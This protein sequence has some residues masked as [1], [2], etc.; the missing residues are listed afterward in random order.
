MLATKEKEFKMLEKAAAEFAR[1]ELS[2][3]RE[4][5]DKYPFGPFWDDI[6]KKA[7]DLDFFHVLLPETLEGMGLGMQSFCILL[8]NICEVDASLAGIIFTNSMAQEIILAT[9]GEPVLKSM[10]DTATDVYGHLFAFPAFANP[11]EIEPTVTAVPADDGRYELSGPMEYLVLGNIAGNAL[12]PAKIKGKTGYV[13]FTCDMASDGVEKSE[14][15]LSLGLHACPAVD[16]RFFRAKADLIGDAG[17]GKAVFDAVSTRMQCAAAAMAAGIMKGSFK[18][19]FDY[20]K[21]R[22]QGGRQIIKWSEVQM[23][24]AEMAVQVKIAETVVEQAGR[25]IDEK[26][27]GW[28]DGSQAAAIHVCQMACDH[29]CNGIQILGGVGYMKDYGQEKRFRD[30]QQ[31]QSLLGLAPMKKIGYIHRKMQRI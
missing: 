11:S 29:T 3:N 25:S 17:N 2:P 10:M 28:E 24:L 15:V 18:E 8:E 23:I 9:G 21:E 16:V 27:K 12:I 4:E 6:V 7:F 31:I 26:Q 19:A 13:F 1:K 14:P 20:S 22:F 5:N 30:A